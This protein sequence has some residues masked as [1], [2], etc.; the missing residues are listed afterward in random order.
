MGSLTF[1]AAERGKT[2]SVPINDDRQV[3]ADESVK[4]SLSTPVGGGA[5]TGQ[6]NLADLIIVDNDGRGRSKHDAFWAGYGDWDW[7]QE[8]WLK[9][10]RGAK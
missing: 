10:R 8:W 7:A 5:T 2:F 1:N 6:R 4:L 3:E 9:T